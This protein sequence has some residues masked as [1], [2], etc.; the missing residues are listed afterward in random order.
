MKSTTIRFSEPVYHELERASRF[1]G[2]PINSIVTVACLNWLG[3]NLPVPAA[4]AG[5]L[6]TPALELP[7]LGR[8][9]AL[10]WLPSGRVRAGT[11]RLGL[12]SWT[13]AASDPLGIFTASA[14]E[15]LGAAREVA[16]TGR[17]PWIGTTHLL[18][19]LHAVEESRAGQALRALA[20]DVAALAAAGEPEQ[21]GERQGPLAP[22]NQVR[23]AVR[24]AHDEA[25][26]QGSPQLGTDHLLLGLLQGPS[27]VAEALAAAAVTPG[28]VRE[29]LAELEPE[30]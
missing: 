27:R 18:Q 10:R 20:V 5:R 14:Q 11:Q 13:L 29:A 22:T 21:E 17:Q 9:A 16:E 24:L 1:V 23:R 2:L 8:A 19:G 12:A 3:D 4:G 28:H 26:A 25:Q 7:A 30:L 15:A 6:A